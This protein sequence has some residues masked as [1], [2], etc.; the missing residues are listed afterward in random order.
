M[1]RGK[2]YVVRTMLILGENNQ[3]E[4]IIELLPEVVYDRHHLVPVSHRQCTPG[5][6]TPLDIYDHQCY[7]LLLC[8]FADHRSQQKKAEDQLGGFHGYSCLAALVICAC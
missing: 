5:H 7:L 3:V 6:E 1:Y 4:I 2:R 8:W